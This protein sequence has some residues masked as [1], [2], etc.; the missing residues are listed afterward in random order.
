MAAS[1]CTLRQFR[2]RTRGLAC[3][4]LVCIVTSLAQRPDGAEVLGPA[5]DL[6]VDRESDDR[7]YY[8]ENRGEEG[9]GN[10]AHHDPS[11]IEAAAGWLL[12]YCPRENI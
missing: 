6:D 1:T 5:V 9:D 7:A 12:V 4:D 2:G 8:R 11:R 3:S 10:E